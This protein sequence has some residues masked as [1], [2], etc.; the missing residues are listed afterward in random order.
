MR[1]V[2]RSRAGMNRRDVHSEHRLRGARCRRPEAPCM[3]TSACGTV[4]RI[5][6][7]LYLKCREKAA[8]EASPTA[9]IIDSQSVKSAERGARIDSHG[10]D[11]GKLIKRSGMFWSIRKACCCTA[12]SPPPTFRIATAVSRC[13]RPCSV[14]FPFSGNCSP[15]QGPVFHRALA[16][17]LPDLET[18]IVKR[19][20]RVK[21][22]VVQPRRWVVERPSPGSTAA[23][24]WPRTGRTSTATRA[25]I[26]LASIRLM[27]RKLCNPT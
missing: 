6:H 17:I 26:K 20:D 15:H 11:A 16:G 5:H 14:C 13:W 4:D 23:A 9:C 2:P 10:F 24:D 25:F 22:F 3:I 8:R 18:E 1:N 21:G 7:A 19:S 12:S 27:L